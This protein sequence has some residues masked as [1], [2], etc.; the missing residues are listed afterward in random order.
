MLGLTSLG[1]FHTAIGLIAVAAGAVALVR[2]KAIDPTQRV[3]Q[4]YLV[5]TLVTVLTGFGIFQHGGFGKP[6]ALGVL[7]LLVLALAAV[8]RKTRAF[9]RASIYVET[10]S[11]TTTFFFHFVPGITE[12]FVRLPVG[13]S[14]QIRTLRAGTVRTV[15]LPESAV[16]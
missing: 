14:L 16:S 11:Y 13:A 8:A 15:P 4:V 1:M 6:H 3:G 7:T 9:G 5:T 2:D 12:T 10:L